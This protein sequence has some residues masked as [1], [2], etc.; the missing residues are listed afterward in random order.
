MLLMNEN[1]A[2]SALRIFL[3]MAVIYDKTLA[4]IKSMNVRNMS[5]IRVILAKIF[6][7]SAPFPDV[8]PRQYGIKFVYVLLS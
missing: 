4:F 7:M 1:Y 5:T 2:M 3:E 8:F 6:Q